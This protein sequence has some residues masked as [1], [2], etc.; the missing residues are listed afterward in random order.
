MFCTRVLKQSDIQFWSAFLR[1]V[2]SW[3]KK[4]VT[5][6]R[7][8]KFHNVKNTSWRRNIRHNVKNTSWRQKVCHFANK[9]AMT[10]KIFLLKRKKKIVPCLL[11]PLLHFLRCV[12]HSSVI[13]NSY[14]NILL[15]LVEY[16]SFDNSMSCTD[17][18]SVNINVFYNDAYAILLMLVVWRLRVAPFQV[19]GSSP[20]EY[21]WSF[22]LSYCHRAHKQPCKSDKPE[23]HCTIQTARFTFQD[24]QTIGGQKN[25]SC[26]EWIYI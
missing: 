20:P 9:F 10:L 4:Y 2:T 15:M 1:L 5:A 12:I 14:D 19:H 16:Y 24:W 26:Q 23:G 18:C 6:S 8:T 11:V 7:N 22:T 3:H 13:N 21:G 25:M 17:F